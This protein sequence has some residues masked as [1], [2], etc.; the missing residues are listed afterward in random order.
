[1]AKNLLISIIT[2]N[3]NNIDGLKKTMTSVL[4]Q[5]FKNFEYIIIDG[6]STDGS[7]AYIESQNKNIDYWVSEPDIGIYNAMNKGI[8]KATGK[9]VS[10]MN[11]GDYFLSLNTLQ[12]CS[13]IFCNFRA[14]VF[15]GQIKFDD[16]LTE[17]TMIYPTKLTLAYLQN[18]VI[19][20]QA[21]FFLL[22][23]LLKFKGY[24]EEYKLAADYH[25][26][27]KL[28][29]NGKTFHPIVFPTVKYDVTGVSSLQMDSYKVEMNQVWI[30]TVPSLLFEIENK[31]LNLLATI[32]N[33]K[34]LKIAF[35]VREYKLRIFNGK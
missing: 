35:K 3:F 2:I 14:D 13:T 34:I 1:M 18:M 12:L 25:Y 24:N 15:Y 17:K 22:D 6:G 29:V 32:K 16:S 19:N 10:F 23:T 20:H 7:A 30:N 21:C 26:Y 4:G 11:S 33:S 28:Y 5:T 31:Y 9:Y 27:L 8:A